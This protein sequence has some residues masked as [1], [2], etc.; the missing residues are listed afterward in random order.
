LVNVCS[1]PIS[2][3]TIERYG[4]RTILIWGAVGMVVCQF[5]VAI[6]GVTD[7]QNPSAVR[8]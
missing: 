6:I 5:I 2:F 8:A 4:R 1:T 7:G 3:Y